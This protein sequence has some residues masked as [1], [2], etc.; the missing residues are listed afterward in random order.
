MACYP[1]TGT[2]YKRHVDNPNKDGRVVTCI[3]YLNKDW[4]TEVSDSTVVIS[5]FV[6]VIIYI[7]RGRV[8]CG[9]GFYVIATHRYNNNNNNA[10]TSGIFYLYVDIDWKKN[11]DYSRRSVYF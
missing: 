7:I 11:C 10:R 6:R 9:A 4:N 1:G 8:V 3:L 5:E 2:Y